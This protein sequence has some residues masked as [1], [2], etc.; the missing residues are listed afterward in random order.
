MLGPQ[1]IT[2]RALAE[3]LSPGS[4]PSFNVVASVILSQQER[5]TWRILAPREAIVMTFLT[6]VVQSFEMDDRGRQED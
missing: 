2:D 4:L 3:T 5:L 6:G 1:N